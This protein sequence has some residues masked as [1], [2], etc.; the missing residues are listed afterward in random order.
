MINHHIE[1]HFGRISRGWSC[2]E[3]GT[4]P[5]QVVEC[6]NGT[7]PNV[8][9]FCSV[10][11]CSV[12]FYSKKSRRKIK[13]EIILSF[14]KD[15]I[16][17]NPVSIIKQMADQ[18]L[19]CREAYLENQ[20]I[21][22]PGFIFDEAYFTGLWI[23][24]PVFFGEEAFVYHGNDTQGYPCIIAWLVPLFPSEIDFI[25][26]NG[27]D[28]FEDILEESTADLFLTTRQGV[29]SHNEEIQPS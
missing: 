29:V 9:S 13:H 11:L 28:R 24:P 26:K 8:V 27:A 22:R 19:E 3:D 23:K 15:H 14:D 21:T 6:H 18:A 2:A 16:P 10:G 5:Y 12:D 4:H 20:I 7:V 1:K 17:S 25:K